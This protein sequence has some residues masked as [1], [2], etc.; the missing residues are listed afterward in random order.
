MRGRCE[1]SIQSI[2]QNCIFPNCEGM[3]YVL[4]VHRAFVFYSNYPYM[5]RYGR[6]QREGCAML[7]AREAIQQ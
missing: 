7:C 2:V 5:M 4:Y 3:L 1:N 6:A